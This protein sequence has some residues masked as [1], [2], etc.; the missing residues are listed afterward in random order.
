MSNAV[1]GKEKMNAEYRK[2]GM[3]ERQIKRIRSIFDQ[4]RSTIRNQISHKSGAK[5]FKRYITKTI[6]RR[7]S[8]K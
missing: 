6:R 2:L 4:N 7:Y 3:T 1:I 8:Y 5:A